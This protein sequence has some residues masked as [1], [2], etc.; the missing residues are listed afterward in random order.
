VEVYLE[1]ILTMMVIL[2]IYNVGNV[3]DALALRWCK[4]EMPKCPRCGYEVVV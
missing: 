4:L 1:Y 2:L 3:K